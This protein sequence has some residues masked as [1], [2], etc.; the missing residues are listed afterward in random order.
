MFTKDHFIKLHN[1]TKVVH[2]ISHIQA[3]TNCSL[4]IYLLRRIQ[5]CVSFSD[6]L[7]IV[8]L[9]HFAS[10]RTLPKMQWVHIQIH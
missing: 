1:H 9:M 6:S 8:A 4:R 3:F 2:L 5:T 7:G 10:L